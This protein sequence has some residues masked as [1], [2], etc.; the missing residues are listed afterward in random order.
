MVGVNEKEEED[1][2]AQEE[3]TEEDAEYDDIKGEGEKTNG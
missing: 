3:V 1:K 2:E